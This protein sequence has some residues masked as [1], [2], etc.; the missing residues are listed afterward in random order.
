MKRRMIERTAVCLLLLTAIFAGSA[1]TAA[2]GSAKIVVFVYND[3]KNNTQN[4]KFDPGE[5]GLA[6]W[7]IRV[8]G[9]DPVVWKSTLLYTN[10]TGYASYNATAGSMY[11]L[12]ETEQNWVN[13]WVPSLYPD[14]I[15]VKIV[16]KGDGKPINF[17]VFCRP[18]Q[19]CTPRT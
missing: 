5:Q 2:A 15:T 12:A 8:T 1:F 16:F 17:A 10:D 3:N 7:I 13:G 6:N 18:L 11:F 9:P 19:T 4:G 14:G